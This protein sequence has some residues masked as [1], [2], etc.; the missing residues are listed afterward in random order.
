VPSHPGGEK[1]KKKKGRTRM[2]ISLL[3][4]V[5]NRRQKGKKEG[6]KKTFLLS[7]EGN[8]PLVTQESTTWGEGGGEERKI[9]H[10]LGRK[11]G[12]KPG[13]RQFIR[14]KMGEISPR[15]WGGGRKG[16][17]ET[18]LHPVKKKGEEVP[19]SLLCREEVSL[20]KK[21]EVFSVEKN[22]S[23]FAS[24]QV[25]QKKRRPHPEREEK[26]KGESLSI[27]G[28]KGDNPL[29]RG[30]WNWSRR[31]GKREEFPSF[32]KKKKK[33]KSFLPWGED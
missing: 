16:K 25:G 18:S 32:R 15:T 17:G 27:H 4:A 20:Q 30:S 9:S 7:E 19:S 12:I 31:R 14:K 28:Q 22:G 10:L 13:P 2:H 8:R 21:R 29:P 23:M 24:R 33:K 3:V 5:R 6:G 26:R 1:K 11:K